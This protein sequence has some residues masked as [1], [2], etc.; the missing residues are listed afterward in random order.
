MG[1]EKRRGEKGGTRRKKEEEGKR[2]HKLSREEAYMSS[3][4]KIYHYLPKPAGRNSV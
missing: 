3:P 4:N 2:N 1:G